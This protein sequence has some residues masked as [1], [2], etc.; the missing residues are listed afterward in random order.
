MKIRNGFV[1][2][3]SSSS[4]IIR[5]IQTNITELKKNFPVEI[6]EEDD[7]WQLYSKLE[8]YGLNLE[9]AEN[10]FELTGEW[11][12][13]I[14]GQ[15]M[16]RL[17]DGE[18]VEIEDYSEQDEKIKQHLEEIGLKVKLPLK[19]YVQFISDDNY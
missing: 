15:E 12:E 11:S 16:G 19:T 10:Y 17:K 13:V 1:S 8:V 3:S 6:S 4:F 14:V 7:Y 9:S 18:P 2:N 5:G